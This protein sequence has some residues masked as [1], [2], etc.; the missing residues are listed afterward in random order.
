MNLII[1]SYKEN[2]VDSNDRKRFL[3]FMNI[4]VKNREKFYLYKQNRKTY[5]LYPINGI[6]FAIPI[7][8]NW[9]TSIIAEYEEIGE[10]SELINPSW[11][12]IENINEYCN[13][14]IDMT[15][16]TCIYNTIF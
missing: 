11:E 14:D 15:V 13:R 4:S 12:L 7:C 8:S 9:F 2:H 16:L 6:N 10:T 1:K 5:G 3:E